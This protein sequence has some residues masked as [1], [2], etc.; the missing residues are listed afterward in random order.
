MLFT[1]RL[2]STTTLGIDEKLLS[3]KT[4]WLTLRAASLPAAMA[5]EQS[6]SLIAK[7]S[8]TPSPIIATV[9]PFAFC[10]LISKHFCS[11]VTLPNT[12]YWLAASTTSCEEKPSNDIYLSASATPTLLATSETV[13]GLSPLIIFICTSFSLNQ[14]IVSIASSLIWSS[15]AITQR[16]SI[17]GGSSS[18]FIILR[19]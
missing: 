2:P 10:A 18:S 9:C 8:F 7:I 15:M 5:T 14:F 12:V 1:T 13:S 6:A 4:R 16:G 17:S 3:N 19:L 11:G